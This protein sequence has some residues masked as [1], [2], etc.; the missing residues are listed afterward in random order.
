MAKTGSTLLQWVDY[1]GHFYLETTSGKLVESLGVIGIAPTYKDEE[2][3][4]YYYSL[5]TAW[6]RLRVPK[7]GLVK[8]G[9]YPTARQKGTYVLMEE[10]PKLEL[11][12]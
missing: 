12:K 4:T 5:P 10:R 1:E 6:L 7:K 2:T 3:G 9:W 8:L 11:V